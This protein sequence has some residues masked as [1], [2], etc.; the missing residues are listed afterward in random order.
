MG[1]ASWGFYKSP[2]MFY[3][4]RE[5]ALNSCHLIIYLSKEKVIL[6]Y[7][8]GKCLTCSTRDVFHARFFVLPSKPHQTK[9]QNPKEN[10]A[11]IHANLENPL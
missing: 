2:L 11:I 3:N 9:R 5:T 7:S 1:A 10:L 8:D 6:V 4:S